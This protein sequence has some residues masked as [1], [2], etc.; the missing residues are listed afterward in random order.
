MVDVVIADDE[1]ISLMLFKRLVE[2][3]GHTVVA[4]AHSIDETIKAVKKHKPA[5]VILDVAMEERDSGL[6]ACSKIKKDKPETSVIFVSGYKEEDF[7]DELRDIDFE[8]F[9]EKP[10]R[11]EH[12]NK[13]LKTIKL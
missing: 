5:I 9:L 13:I 12:L 2:N 3:C 7:A 6:K 8:G 10:V 11:Q 1:F 4:E